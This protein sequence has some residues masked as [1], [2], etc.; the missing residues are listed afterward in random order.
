VAFKKSDYL[1]FRDATT[2]SSKYGYRLTA[3][4]HEEFS[5]SQSESRSVIALEGFI[6]YLDKFLVGPN[7]FDEELAAGYIEEIQMIL[8][9]F[10][11]SKIFSE[12]DFVG[13]S[14]LLMHCNGVP[15]V[16][17]IDF[18]NVTKAPGLGASPDGN[19]L[20]DGIL[21]LLSVLDGLIIKHQ[22]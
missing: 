6:K 8:A 21:G 7:G 19:G 16:R 9:K 14:L 4:H 20:I 11:E 2:T 1:L 22:L 17:W 3:V 13:T 18:A 10:R 12:Y 5:V 15:A